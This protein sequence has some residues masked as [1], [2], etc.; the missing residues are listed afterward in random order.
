MRLLGLWST[1]YDLVDDEKGNPLP[2]KL[3]L[4]WCTKKSF[5]FIVPKNPH[6]L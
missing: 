2:P 3:H 6:Y 4:F 1:R 5:K